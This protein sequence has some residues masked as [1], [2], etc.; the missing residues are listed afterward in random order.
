MSK[1]LFGIWGA[2]SISSL[3]NC[4][5][6]WNNSYF[7][8]FTFFFSKILGGQRGFTTKYGEDIP[9]VSTSDDSSFIIRPR[10]QP[11]FGISGD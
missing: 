10:H 3:E 2:K 4:L 11:I 8:I 9:I 7:N 6:G 1:Y 5:I